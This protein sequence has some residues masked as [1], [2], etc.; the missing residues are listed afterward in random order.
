MYLLFK[1]AGQHIELLGGF[2]IENELITQTNISETIYVNDDFHDS[3]DYPEFDGD[4]N[5]S[6]PCRGDEYAD[7]SDW[8]LVCST[9]VRKRCLTMWWYQNTWLLRRMLRSCFSRLTRRQADVDSEDCSDRL[10][11]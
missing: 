5:E 2:F 1:W 7:D 3:F 4:C 8:E 10:P 11:F 6:Q 9:A